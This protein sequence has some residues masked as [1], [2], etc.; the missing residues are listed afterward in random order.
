MEARVLIVVVGLFALAAVVILALRW[1]P[2]NVHRLDG[3]WR[4]YCLQIIIVGYILLPA[5]FGGIVLLLMLL[6][7][8]ARIQFEMFQLYDA[9]IF[10]ISQ[11]VAYTAAAAGVIAAFYNAPGLAAGLLVAGCLLV[12][13]IKVVKHGTAI[14]HSRNIAALSL[15]FPVSLIAHLALLGRLDQGFIWLAVVYIIVELNDSFAFIFGKSFGVGRILPGLSPNKTTVGL[16]AGFT[17]ALIV[18]WPLVWY[19]LALSPFQAFGLVV[20][21]AL[22]GFFGDLLTSALK[23]RQGKKDF[24][25]LS[26]DHGGALD[27][28]DSLL[29]AAPFCLAFQHWA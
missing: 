22:G 15:L 13:V 17:A 4:L 27:I 11:I 20:V 21:I 3:L 18:G 16:L 10:G 8:T 14:C 12:T 23:R 9:P 28:Y 6:V 25:P 26:K 1:G 29:M 2:W 5:Y 24:A 19:L 7:L